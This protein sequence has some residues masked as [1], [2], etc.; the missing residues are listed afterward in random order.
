M[1]IF[2]IL[3]CKVSKQSMP[4]EK[5]T[6]RSNTRWRNKKPMKYLHNR[7]S[8]SIQINDQN[9]PNLD[10]RNDDVYKYKSRIIFD[11][12]SILDGPPHYF[13]L[14]NPTASTTTFMIFFTT[15]WIVL[16]DCVIIPSSSKLRGLPTRF[17]VKQKMEIGL[18]ATFLSIASLA[19]V[20]GKRRKMTIDKGFIA[21]HDK[22]VNMSIM[23][24]RQI[25]DGFS[26]AFNGVGQNEFFM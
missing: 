9:H 1:F 25:L 12:G 13:K 16:Y 11:I 23:W 19:I 3:F 4:Y 10:N 8:R 21:Y 24:L 17:K 22:V 26:D 20:E 18:I 2:L 5:S 7:P 14:R 15:L 6:T